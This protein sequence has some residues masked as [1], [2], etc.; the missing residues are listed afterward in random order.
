MIVHNNNNNNRRGPALEH[1]FSVRW[2]AEQ[3]FEIHFGLLLMIIIW[4]LVVL[5]GCVGD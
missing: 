3:R 5:P 2:V 4:E 1:M